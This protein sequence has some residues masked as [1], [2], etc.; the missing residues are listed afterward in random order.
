MNHCFNA[1]FQP[2]QDTHVDFDTYLYLQAVT[3]GAAM[4]HPCFLDAQHFNT[5]YAR[6]RAALDSMKRG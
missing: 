5:A 2:K 3:T 1:H 6:L 4:L